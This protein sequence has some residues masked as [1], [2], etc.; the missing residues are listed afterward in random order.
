[1]VLKWINSVVRGTSHEAIQ[2]GA[3]E[4]T[5][6]LRRLEGRD[7]AHEVLRLQA[8]QKSQEL[9]GLVRRGTPHLKR[10]QF[11]SC[12]HQRVFEIVSKNFNLK[13]SRDL[14]EITEEITDQIVTA[15]DADLTYKSMFDQQ[16]ED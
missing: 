13:P 7:L 16:K 9:E 8:K 1:M 10:E 12:V 4:Q 11:K 2:Q 15:A 5:K 14:E 6:K 3:N